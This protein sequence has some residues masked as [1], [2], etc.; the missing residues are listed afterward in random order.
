MPSLS[1]RLDRLAEIIGQFQPS[2]DD[3]AGQLVAFLPSLAGK[4]LPAA[5][6]LAIANGVAKLVIGAGLYAAPGWKA[7]DPS[8]DPRAL[9]AIN[10]ALLK[11]DRWI[12]GGLDPL[13]AVATWLADHPCEEDDP[14]AE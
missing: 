6:T 14:D 7:D 11:V 8:P 3:V 5:R 2:A 4:D 1:T 9:D 13:I 12:F 10:A